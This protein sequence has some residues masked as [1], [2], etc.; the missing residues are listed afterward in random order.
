MRRG[1]EDER[2]DIVTWRGDSIVTDR[3]QHSHKQ[4]PMHPRTRTCE[5]KRSWG[6]A[7]VVLCAD[8]KRL[9]STH[10]FGCDRSG[11]GRMGMGAKCARLH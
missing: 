7:E 1:E 6:R 10:G 8:A 11:G 4:E 9:Q 3:H 2:G 5:S